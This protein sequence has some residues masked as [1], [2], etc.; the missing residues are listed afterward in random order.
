MRM[1]TDELEP[2]STSLVRSFRYVCTSRRSPGYP[3]TTVVDLGQRRVV[4]GLGVDADPQL[5]EV[6]AD[7]LVGDQRL[8]DV[9]AAVAH[10]LDALE[11]GAALAR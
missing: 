4:V 3:S 5:G 1:T 7:D 11:F 2:V 10:A 9:G 6:D 8:S